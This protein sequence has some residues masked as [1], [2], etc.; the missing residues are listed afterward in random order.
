MM[1]THTITLDI[2]TPAAP[3]RIPVQQGDA[4]SRRVAVALT[5]AGSPWPVPEGVSA[6]IRYAATD[7][8][9]GES[10]HGLYDTLP[11]GEAAWSVEEH[12]L[13]FIPSPQMF[14]RPGI[15]R[16]DLVLT[17]EEQVLITCGF[18]FSVSPGPVDVLEPPVTD[19]Y[20]VVTLEQINQALEQLNTMLDQTRQDVLAELSARDTRLT[21][22]ELRLD[23]LEQ[24]LDHM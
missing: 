14:A 2:Q 10:F 8:A 3:A 12:I 16:A 7:P 5:E 13:Y 22:L 9:T 21:Q 23:T 15:V 11:T 18:E 19:Y 4:L 6:V 17:Q 1:T 20:Q 24:A